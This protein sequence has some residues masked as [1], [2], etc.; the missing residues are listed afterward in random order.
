MD[1]NIFVYG[2]LKEKFSLD[3]QCTTKRKLV[4]KNI[5]INGTLF[6]L[7]PF[8]GVKFNTKDVV[9]GEI[10]T[11]ENKKKTLAIMDSIEGYDSKNKNK[12]LFIRKLIS[13]IYKNNKIKAYAYEFNFN[14]YNDIKKIKIKTGIWEEEIKE[15]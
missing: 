5:K 15:K 12:S 6:N 8:P 1:V 13:I 4:I 7:G 2:T 11:F 9:I 10:H 3:G 14:K